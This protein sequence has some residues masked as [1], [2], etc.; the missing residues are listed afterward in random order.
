MKYIYHGFLLSKPENQQKTLKAKIH[1]EL[2]EQNTSEREKM[3]Q[4]FCTC[5]L[6][7]GLRM[8]SFPTRSGGSEQWRINHPKGH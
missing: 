7:P 1:F 6:T 2:I 4:S 8:S 5:N 3:H